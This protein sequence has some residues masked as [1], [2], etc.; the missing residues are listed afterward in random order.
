MN[1][2]GTYADGGREEAALA[3]NA[4][5]QTFRESD[6]KDNRV[7]QARVLNQIAERLNAEL[8][9]SFYGK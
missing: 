3:T 8:G 6:W 2:L 7:L 5:V 4:A 9:E 1:F